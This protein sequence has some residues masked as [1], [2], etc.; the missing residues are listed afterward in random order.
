MKPIQ[1][2][3]LA[4]VLLGAGLFGGGYA[5]GQIGGVT[6]TS[7][8]SIAATAT[9]IGTVPDVGGPHDGRG[10]DAPHADGTVTAIN[11]DTL[12]ISADTDPSGTDEYTKVATVNLT[13][14]TTYD[15]GHDSTTTAS[16]SSIKV[17]SYIIVDGTVSN[18]GT[19]ITAS[20]V[21]IMAGGPIAG[22]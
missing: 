19:T 18:D 1:K 4:A 16:K 6:G 11:G 15:A 13:S 20:N 3:I 12:T 10:Q 8:A 22:R 21:G 7:A 9:T 17:G 2:P 14:S 5:I